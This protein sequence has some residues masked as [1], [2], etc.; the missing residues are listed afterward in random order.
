MTEQLVPAPVTIS[1]SKALAYLQEFYISRGMDAEELWII[2][3]IAIVKKKKAERPSG[4]QY[5]KTV[6]KYRNEPC[7]LLFMNNASIRLLTAE[8]S[9]EITS[10]WQVRPNWRRKTAIS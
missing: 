3:H 5:D 2:Y 6:G 7:M 4:Q 8:D 10:S 9:G 1:A